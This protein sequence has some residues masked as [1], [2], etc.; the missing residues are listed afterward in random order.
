MNCT[1]LIAWPRREWFKKN[2]KKIEINKLHT[3]KLLVHAV[4]SF[5]AQ[6][7]KH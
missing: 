7:R 2:T 3:D 5:N 6:V 1:S 4:N